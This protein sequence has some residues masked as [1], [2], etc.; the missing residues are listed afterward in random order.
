RAAG[1]CAGVY[2][3][4]GHVEIILEKNLR[5]QLLCREKSLRSADGIFPDNT[6]QR[7]GFKCGCMSAGSLSIAGISWAAG[8]SRIWRRGR[9]S[10]Q[11][12]ILR[13]YVKYF[14]FS[15]K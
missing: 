12:E 3:N 11:I 5:R 1:R 2:H 14:D 9:G 4:P 7:C 8:G 10:L 15:C 13:I 6:N